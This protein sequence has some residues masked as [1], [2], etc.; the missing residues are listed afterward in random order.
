MSYY[1]QDHPKT[2]ENRITIATENNAGYKANRLKVERSEAL[3]NSAFNFDKMQV[4]YG[5]DQNNLAINNE[6][7][8]VFGV[9]QDFLFPTVYFTHKKLNKVNVNL[10]SSSYAIKEKALQREITSNYYSQSVIT[11]NYLT[12]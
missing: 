3:I 7:I 4:Y 5:Y 2:L 1:G 6:P 12:F 11:I 10:E 9:Q 8:G